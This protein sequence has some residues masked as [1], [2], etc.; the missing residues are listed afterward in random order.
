MLVASLYILSCSHRHG[1]PSLP[2]VYKP[3]QVIGAWIGFTDDAERAYK[4][5]LRTNETGELFVLRSGGE[6]E[7]NHIE[8]WWLQGAVWCN[9]HS[10]LPGGETNFFMQYDMRQWRVRRLLWH[11]DG[12]ND[13]QFWREDLIKSAA[14]RFPKE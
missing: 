4:L 6:L 11:V 2:I 7:T 1:H 10:R 8:R 9:L 5:I 13:I 3:S 14:S 12:T